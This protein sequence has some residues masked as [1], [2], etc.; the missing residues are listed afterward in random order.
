[1]TSRELRE[2]TASEPLTLREEY[3]MQ[4]ERP[5]AAVILKPCLIRSAGKWQVDGDKL[6][7]IVL[8]GDGTPSEAEVTLETLRALPM[9]GDV[10]LFLKGAPGAEDFE[11][12]VEVM[13]AG[14]AHPV[15]SLVRRRCQFA[16]RFRADS[17]NPFATMAEPAFRRRGLASAALQLMLSYATSPSAPRPLP[18]A[19]E[20]LVAR[21]GERNVAS[22]RLFEKLGFA[23]TRR[24]EVFGEVEM[25]FKG[26]DAMAWKQG[27]Q[28]RLETAPSESGL[29]T[30][31]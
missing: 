17:R 12:E 9:I 27:R 11:A 23:V 4:S 28:Q 30:E 3:E 31:Q 20:R 10:N 29:R 2:L 15:P 13:I 26:A 1:M 5:C 7:F 16:D 21:I 22:M 14:I 18:V 6:T 24:V 8:A 25:R 19:R